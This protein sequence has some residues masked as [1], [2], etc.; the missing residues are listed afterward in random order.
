MKNWKPWE[1]LHTRDYSD[2]EMM[3]R[4]SNFSFAHP[5]ADS[6]EKYDEM[7]HSRGDRRPSAGMH[8]ED[9]E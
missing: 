4:F 3:H 6:F 2:K 9:K 8:P 7:K 5:F 1:Y